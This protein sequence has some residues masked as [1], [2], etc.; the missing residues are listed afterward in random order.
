LQNEALRDSQAA[1]EASRMR[2]FTFYDTGERIPT[3]VAMET[4]ESVQ[5][6]GVLVIVQVQAR[7]DSAK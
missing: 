3:L 7:G 5:E 4:L 1:L 2:Y 6:P